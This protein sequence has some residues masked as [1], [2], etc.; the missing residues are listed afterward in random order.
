MSD[1]LRDLVTTAASS[2]TIR[3]LMAV[4]FLLVVV[5]AVLVLRLGGLSRTVI[6]R[7][8]RVFR[9]PPWPLDRFLDP[10]SYY[11]AGQRLLPWGL[12][13][14]SDR[15]WTICSIGMRPLRRKTGRGM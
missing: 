5:T 4:E 9:H 11:P 15:R 14:F 13:S 6:P 3:W 7:D 2:R 12:G 1:V 10:S 8:L